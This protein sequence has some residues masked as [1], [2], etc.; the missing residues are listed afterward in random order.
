MASQNGSS[1][2]GN[3]SSPGGGSG[4]A[5]SELVVTATILKPQTLNN[6]F[7]QGVLLPDEEVDLK[8]LSHPE[9]YRYLL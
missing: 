4:F 6:L 8:H 1:V 2:N 9:N 5:R 3:Q 7:H